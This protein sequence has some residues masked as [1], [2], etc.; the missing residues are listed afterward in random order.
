MNPLN[1]ASSPVHATPTKSTRPAHCCAAASTEG[2]SALQIV[3]V[4]AQNQNAV[5]RPAKSAPANWP[6]P[7]SGAV[8]CN[9][10]GT[11]ATP[12]ALTS[13]ACCSAVDAE[14]PHPTNEPINT[15][16][17]SARPI[18]P[19]LKLARSDGA[20][21][22]VTT[23]PL[24]TDRHATADHESTCFVKVSR[25]RIQSVGAGRAS[26]AQR[27]HPETLVVPGDATSIGCHDRGSS[28]LAAPLRCPH[29]SGAAIAVVPGAQQEVFADGRCRR[30]GL[31]TSQ[32]PQSD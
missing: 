18:I 15:A 30:D 17:L 3:Q 14:L 10:C 22:E 9:S 11:S 31:R 4:G 27:N 19:D 2:A 13:T 26:F 1:D 7:T 8:N 29:V 20:L 23:D 32:T 6:P 24:S 5:A 25:R 21:N 28:L 12:G 16:T